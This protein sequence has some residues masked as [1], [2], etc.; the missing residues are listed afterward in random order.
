MGDIPVEGDLGSSSNPFTMPEQAISTGAAAAGGGSV[1]P[2]IGTL[3]GGALGGIGSIFSG[4]FAQSSAREQMR[5]QERMSN[6]AHQREV[7]DLRA[8][9]LNPMLSAKLGGASSPAGA[10]AT[11]PNPG[12]SMGSAV[13]GSA[14]MY[15]LELP[16]LEASI[17]LQAAQEEAQRSSAENSRASAALSLAQAR[18]VDPD[19]RVKELTGDRI[20]QLLKPEVGETLAHKALMEKQREVAAATARQ[21]KAETDIARARLPK[22]QFE[23]SDFGIGLD[24]VGKVGD[25]VGSFTKAGAIGK[26]V[27]GGPSSGASV[28]RNLKRMSR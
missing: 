20:E 6:T 17:R 28:L 27:F 4:L 12:E 19:I 18:A 24:A 11:M 2:G 23:A 15:A 8:A 5:F 9:G 22:V 26:A 3:I 25:A 13:S 16:Q 1:W 14:R 7:K 10:A 21:V